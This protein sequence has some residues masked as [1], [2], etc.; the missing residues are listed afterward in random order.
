MYRF[1]L[2][3]AIV[4]PLL[5]TS[6]TQGLK[7]HGFI[8]IRKRRSTFNDRIAERKKRTSSPLKP[9]IAPS[10]KPDKAGKSDDYVLREV[11]TKY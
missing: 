11:N 6:P 1:P 10:K 9:V 2:G 7:R 8:V 4:S 3:P 5:G